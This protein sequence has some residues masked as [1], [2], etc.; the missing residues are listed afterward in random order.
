MDQSKILE[1]G[2]ALG[3]PDEATKELFVI[4]LAMPN[5]KREVIKGIIERCPEVMALVDQVMAATQL[6][7][8][9]SKD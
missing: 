3:I 1:I 5:D 8:P 7:P 9:A 4:L 2:R 6:A